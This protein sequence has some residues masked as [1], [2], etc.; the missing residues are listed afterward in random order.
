MRQLEQLP[1]QENSLRENPAHLL[2]AQGVLAHIYARL[3]VSNCHIHPQAHSTVGAESSEM[4][5]KFVLLLIETQSYP[6]L[7]L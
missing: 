3:G 7:M 4:H 6:L 5:K 2:W 1:G